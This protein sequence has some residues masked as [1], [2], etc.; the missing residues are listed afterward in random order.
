MIPQN[1]KKVKSRIRFIHIMNPVFRAFR[2]RFRPFTVCSR[3]CFCAALRV[4]RGH[5]TACQ[6]TQFE[7]KVK[8]GGR[9]FVCLRFVQ[10]SHQIVYILSLFNLLSSHSHHAVFADPT[11]H[12]SIRSL[13]GYVYFAQ[14]SGQIF[15][16]LA[17]CT[18][19][20]EPRIF[21]TIR[22]FF[23]PFSPIFSVF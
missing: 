15:Y 11:R 1:R 5:S 20:A 13:D 21:R 4:E 6:Q 9:A 18:N 19:F 22:E 8:I 23:G 16:A 3:F 10:M 2:G 12:S 14:I 17:I 7:Q